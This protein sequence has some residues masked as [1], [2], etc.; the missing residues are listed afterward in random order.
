MFRSKYFIVLYLFIIIGC[1]GG[2]GGGDDFAPE[3]PLGTTQGYGVDAVIVDASVAAYSWENGVKGDLLGN[4]TTDE[5]GFYSISIQAPAQPIILELS[6]GHYIEEASGEKVSLTDDQRLYAITNYDG[7][8]LDIMITPFTTLAAGLTQYYVDKGGKNAQNAIT[9]ATSEITGITVFNI[10]TEYPVNI[11]YE[12]NHTDEMTDGHMY[13]F[14]SAAFSSW[15]AEI[16]EENGT[17]AHN[18]YSSVH[19]TD[20]M[21]RDV[22]YDGVLNGEGVTA[23]GKPG[24]LTMGSVEM[25][26]ETYR[27]QIAKHVLVAADAD[28]NQSGLTT[29]DVLEHAHTF[30][31][32][33]NELYGN[34]S[35][36]PLDAEGPR[37]YQTE[38]IDKYYRGEIDYSFRIVDIVGINTVAVSIDGEP[39]EIENPEGTSADVTVHIETAQYDDGEHTI[40]VV[41]TDMLENQSTHTLTFYTNNS[42]ININVD[43]DLSLTRDTSIEI[44]GSYEM[45]GTTIDTITVNGENANLNLEDQTFFYLMPLVEGVNEIMIVGTDTIGNQRELQLSIPVDYTFPEII[46]NDDHRFHTF[47]IGD[48][49]TA[50]LVLHDENT[51]YPLYFNYYNRSLNGIPLIEADLLTAE[52]PFFTVVI[53]DPEGEG[54]FTADDEMTVAMTYH[55]HNEAVTTNTLQ[56]VEGSTNKYLIP[57][58][59]EFL[60]DDFIQCTEEDVHTIQVRA[61]DKAGNNVAK[62][63]TFKAYVDAPELTLATLNMSSKVTVYAWD[64]GQKGGIIAEGRTSREGDAKLKMFADSG[65]ILVELTEG[66]FEEMGTGGTT[67]LEDGDALTAVAYFDRQSLSMNVTP[68]THVARAGAQRL[69]LSGE[70]EETAISS[71]AASL[72]TVYGFDIA[73]TGIVDITDSSSATAMCTDEYR[74][75][76]VL[77]GVS[78]WAYSMGRENGASDLQHFNTIYLADLMAA[79]MANDGRLNGGQDFGSVPLDAEAYQ[80]GLGAGIT[81]VISRYSSYTQ[82]TL[83]DYLGIRLTASEAQEAADI[84]GAAFA[85]RANSV[86]AEVNTVNLAVRNN[87]TR[88]IYVVLNDTEDQSSCT[89]QYYDAIRVHTVKET[90]TYEYAARYNFGVPPSYDQKWWD[91]NPQW[92]GITYY[93]KYNKSGKMWSTVQLPTTEEREFKRTSD[94]V[95]ADIQWDWQLFLRSSIQDCAQ[96]S[97]QTKYNNPVRFQGNYYWIYFDYLAPELDVHLEPWLENEGDGDFYNKTFAVWRKE[98]LDVNDSTMIVPWIRRQ[99]RATYE[100]VDGPRNVIGDEYSDTHTAEGCRLSVVGSSI[101]NPGTIKGYHVSPG[102]KIDVKKYV[103]TPNVSLHSGGDPI[104]ST[105]KY[106]QSLTWNIDQSVSVSVVYGDNLESINQMPRFEMSHS[107]SQTYTI[108]R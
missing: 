75:S 85:D 50:N 51:G 16:S 83:Q 63:L 86:N 105:R 8:D 95:P 7:E 33:V 107:D 94:S 71:A 84:F 102:A 60:T 91:D 12:E 61:T 26:A 25:N 101:E 70:R 31:Q 66:R 32:R 45:S 87:L 41:S 52:I 36:A 23:N 19:L 46:T 13:G 11:T 15:T 100:S 40:E 3:R 56:P 6:G 73:T 22:L 20:L 67:T 103:T 9:H 48:G 27:L 34:E 65:P 5:F 18:P 10:L 80:Q 42:G 24:K 79:D 21:Y 64:N 58:A 39:A 81:E 44:A 89:H 72:S 104:Y 55:L 54:V 62:L 57:L 43:T 99:A 98:K 37:V 17:S 29:D 68:L 4:A 108:E 76:F 93:K 106:D 14:Y 77:G 90:R 2:S 69:V 49:D 88:P 1:G 53:E 74:H 28:Y 92:K 78:R 82:L 30:S 38:P 59:T 97:T 35:P 47:Y 96:P